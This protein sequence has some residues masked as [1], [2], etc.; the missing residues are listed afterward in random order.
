MTAF[1]LGVNYWPRRSAMY[2]WKRFD[3]AEIRDDMASIASL[4][5]RFVRFFLGWEDFQPEPD[6]FDGV[7]RERLVGFADA[8]HAAGLACMPT[9][10]TGHMSGVNWLPE[11]TLDPSR[12]AERFRTVNERGERPYGIG[13]FYRGDLLEA[14]LRF[15]G[16]AGSWLRGHPALYAWDLGNEFSNLR[17]PSSPADAAAWSKRLTDVLE[18][19]SGV[20][21]TAG[22]HGEDL[23]E[24]RAIRPSSISKPWRFATMHGYAAYS[25][26]ARSPADAH[27]VPFL[28]QLTRTF[29]RRDVLFSEVGTP[30]QDAALTVPG[31]TEDGAAAYCDAVID[32]LWRGGALGAGWWCFAD[33]AREL[34]SLPPFDRAPHELSFGIVRADG[35]PK[36]VAN[37]L[38][39]IAAQ[40][41]DVRDVALPPPMDEDAFYAGLPGTLDRAYAASCANEAA[42]RPSR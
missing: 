12:P 39:R 5:L 18:E 20:G 17:A 21:V 31:L 42:S 2:M 16:A 3:L 11:W 26:F 15:A 13:D 38:A 19:R 41:R 35:S 22:L 34:C 10:F 32:G 23:T 33:Y 27:V 1:L 6:R 9:L 37:A 4:G 14:Q 7:M 24:D 36:P 30:A 29:A 40:R 25:H 8:A 28:H